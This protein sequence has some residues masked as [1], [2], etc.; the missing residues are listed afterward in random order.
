[1]KRDDGGR[2]KPDGVWTVPIMDGSAFLIAA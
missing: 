2:N 1:M